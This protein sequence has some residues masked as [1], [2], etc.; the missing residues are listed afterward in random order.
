MKL[1]IAKYFNTIDHEMLLLL[2]KRRFKEKALLDLFSRIFNT[3]ETVPGKGLPIGNLISQHMAN[4]YLGCLDHW[5]K[6]EMRVRGYVRYMDDFVIW[7]EDKH[8]LKSYLHDV[9]QWLM[10]NLALRLNRKIQLNQSSRGMPFLGYRVFPGKILLASSSKKRF[11]RKFQAYEKAFLDG[12][13]GEGVLCRHM[14]SLIEFTRGAAGYGFRA[15]VMARLGRL[16]C[17]N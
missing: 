11:A 13:W 7:G 5:V 8:A 9:E 16:S 2:L 3:Y 6:E 14:G 12:E 10:S 17:L 1:D 4:F 15:N